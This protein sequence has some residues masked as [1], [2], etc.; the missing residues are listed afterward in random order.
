ML[1]SMIPILWVQETFVS[2][3]HSLFRSI[4]VHRHRFHLM[5][6]PI[7]EAW[8]RLGPLGSGSDAS[9][10]IYAIPDQ[11]GWQNLSGMTA[12]LTF[13]FPS[14]RT[15]IL[16][17]VRHINKTVVL[18]SVRSWKWTCFSKPNIFTNT[19]SPLFKTNLAKLVTFWYSGVA[20]DH[21]CI[22]GNFDLVV[23]NLILGSFWGLFASW[24]REVLYLML[25]SNRASGS[26]NFLF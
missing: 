8:I 6:F 26:M 9:S 25:S 10:H 4:H 3:K 22:M 1:L 11:Y 17:H 7:R 12:L 23:Y 19:P 18:V 14:R 16:H 5:S 20:V 15:C 13:Y 24:Y 21:T 2:G